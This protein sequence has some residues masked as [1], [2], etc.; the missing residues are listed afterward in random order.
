[1]KVKLI[2]FLLV[3]FTTSL[4]GCGLDDMMQTL[5][6]STSPGFSGPAKLVKQMEISFYPDNPSHA[7]HYSSEENIGA[8]LTLLRSFQTK[9]TPDRQ[10]NLHDGQ[11]Y[12]TITVTYS[13]D[14]TYQYYLLGHRYLRM[15][16]DQWMEIGTANAMKFIHFLDE[17]PN[18]ASADQ[19]QAILGRQIPQIN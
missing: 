5:P 11:S 9:D 10:P 2:V 16:N 6:L 17:H 14:L 19:I 8:L 13:N 1:M 12:Y 18:D 3:F 4:S 15:G 7:R